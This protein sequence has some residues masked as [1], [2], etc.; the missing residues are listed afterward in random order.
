MLNYN[1]TLVAVRPHDS[2]ADSEFGFEVESDP[3]SEPRIAVLTKPARELVLLSIHD[4]ATFDLSYSPRT[5]ILH[6]HMFYITTYQFILS[7][8]CM[9]SVVIYMNILQIDVPSYQITNGQKHIGKK[10][11]EQ[12]TMYSFAG[13]PY[14][15]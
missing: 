2:D 5:Y 7:L 14:I 8:I 4:S 11:P 3:E 1:E 6:S 10:P 13:D 12:C 9:L 15:C